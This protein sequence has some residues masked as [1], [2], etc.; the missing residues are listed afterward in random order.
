MRIALVSQE[1]PPDTAHGGIGTQ[2]WNKARWLAAHGHEVHVVS[3]QGGPCS[4]G[5]VVRDAGVTV[6]RMVPPGNAFPVYESASY[7]VGYSWSVLAELHGLMRDAPLDLID[8]AEYGAEGFA[9]LLDRTPWNWA[10]VVVQ[11]HGP[12]SLF[13][14]RIGWPA[15]DSDLARVGILME[16]CCI[17]KADA[18][19]ACSANIADFT[20][21]RHGVAR[22]AIDVVHCGV[23]ADAF[24]PPRTPRRGDRPTIA[25]V[26]NIAHNKGAGAVFEAALLLRHKYPGLR[27]RMAG[28]PEGPLADEIRARIRRE[29]AEQTVELCG[30]IGREALETYYQESDIFC[31]PAQHEAGVANVYIEA[32]ACG[33]PVVAS[34]A[35]GGAEAVLPGETGLLVPPSSVEAVTEALDRLLGDPAGRVRMGAAGR[36]RVEAYFAM[37]R[38]M[39]RV[40]AVYARAMETARDRRRKLERLEGV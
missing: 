40:M 15:P 29:H 38:Y 7:W 1:Y 11:L 3:C 34:H 23:D 8:F 12:L 20:A 18:L 13:V 22:N 14:E 30:F 6:H 16:D 2:T 39:E 5:K 21:A 35:G 24:Q 36:R 9:Y 33:L 31:S 17:H 25:F 4:T 19:M 32:M 27:L 37:D 26:G 10:P 28:K